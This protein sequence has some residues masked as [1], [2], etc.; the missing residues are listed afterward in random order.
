MLLN[1]RTLF[2]H[3]GATAGFSGSLWLDP[4]RRRASVVLANAQLALGD[5][6]LHIADDSMPL[7]DLSATR[8][9]SITLP[10]EALKPLAGVYALNPQF[11]LTV[12]ANGARLFAQATGQAE[13]EL[14]AKEPRRF[15]AKVTPLEIE[16]DADARV[17]TLLQ[18]GAKSRFVRE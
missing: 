16:F 4:T 1:G 14:F 17:L 15:F 13:F 11:K 10:A 2:N 5:L 8:Q 9:A 18:G 7:R 12:R 3:D 6:G